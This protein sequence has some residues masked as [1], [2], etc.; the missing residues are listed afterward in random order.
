M[1]SPQPATTRFALFLRGINVGGVKVPM[2]QLREVLTQMGGSSVRSW[3]AS[4][5]V[6]LD[7]PGDAPG[8]Q[9]AAEAVLGERFGYRAR[10]LVRRVDE[11]AA[12]IAA[13]PWAP[14]DGFHRYVVLF[15]DADDAARALAG[16]ASPGSSAGDPGRDG[17]VVP[18]GALLAGE[19][20]QLHGDLI[21]WRC[22]KG[23]TT[24]SAFGKQQNRGPAVR[25]PTVRNLQTLQ[26]M[27]G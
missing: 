19:R 4:G 6:A 3:L 27:V 9:R 24:D 7:W 25:R 10:V 22:P 1:N 26:R 20:V 12:I 15:D 18:A 17:P 23:R 13:C 8:L 14:D 16:L 11:L 5:N 2:A 21:Y